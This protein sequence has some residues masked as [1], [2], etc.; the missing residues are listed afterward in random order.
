[1]RELLVSLVLLLPFAGCGFHDMDGG[2]DSIRAHFAMTEQELDRHA[3]AAASAGSLAAIAEEAGRHT[4]AMGELV[5]RMHGDLDG[6]TCAH[7]ARLEMMSGL[8]GLH[9]HL[10]RHHADLDRALDLETA[11]AACRQHDEDMRM[12]MRGMNM[13]MGRM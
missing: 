7:G 11:R 12:M 2:M 9:D 1:M 4:D 6:M 3:Q 13:A 10:S 5:D 8:T